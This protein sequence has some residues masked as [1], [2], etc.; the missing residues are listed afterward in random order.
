MASRAHSGIAGLGDC[1]CLC[2][3]VLAEL[4]RRMSLEKPE[5][6]YSAPVH[7][8]AAHWP[9]SQHLATA[10][11]LQTPGHQRSPHGKY[12]GD[13]LRYN[14]TANTGHLILQRPV[15]SHSSEALR[16]CGTA[17]AVRYVAMFLCVQTPIVL[18]LSGPHRYHNHKSVQLSLDKF[19]RT[20]YLL[21]QN[22]ATCTLH[23]YTYL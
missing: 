18:V 23:I 14:T 9:G 7:G 12:C 4:C 10:D 17:V 2:N 19:H 22:T 3:R 8:R 11:S 1:E 5:S 16:N 15:A 20:H 6:D 21:S 13:L